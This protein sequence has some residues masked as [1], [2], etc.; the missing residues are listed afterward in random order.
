MMCV[1]GLLPKGNI[2]MPNEQ[3]QVEWFYMTFQK[4]DCM[5]YLRSGRKLSN[6]MHQTIAETFN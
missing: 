5:E 1:V 6:K 3:L 4:S 2:P